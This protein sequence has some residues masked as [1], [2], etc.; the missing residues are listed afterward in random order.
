MS[1]YP[2]GLQGWSSKL[3]AMENYFPGDFFTIKF[4]E[5]GSCLRRSQMS[6]QNVLTA[7]TGLLLLHCHTVTLIN[8]FF[9]QIFLSQ[10]S[11]LFSW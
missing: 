9:Y 4:T 11:L 5:T 6:Q 7:W 2:I 8:N 10:R 3:W 1:V